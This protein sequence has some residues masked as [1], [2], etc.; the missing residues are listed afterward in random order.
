MY[1]QLQSKLAVSKRKT[2]PINLHFSTALN[3]HLQDQL[4]LHIQTDKY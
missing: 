1:Q 2:M 3:E 4:G